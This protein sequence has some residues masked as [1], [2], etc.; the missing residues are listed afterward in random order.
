MIATE[1][2]SA[3]EQFR[4]ILRREGLPGFYRGYW[5][6]VA[7]Y[8]PSRYVG[9]GWGP[10]HII[11]IILIS[12]I[13]TTA[14]NAAWRC[15]RWT[16][17]FPLPFHLHYR[18]PSSFPFLPSPFHLHHPFLSFHLHFNIIIFNII[19]FPFLSASFLIARQRAPRPR[20]ACGPGSPRCSRRARWRA[21]CRTRWAT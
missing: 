2:R 3:A 16:D 21:G 11:I 15:V 6:S 13:H 10:P 9:S 20:S 18:Q 14:A 7:L 12:I 8:V 4:R 19:S 1:R 17:T 5:A